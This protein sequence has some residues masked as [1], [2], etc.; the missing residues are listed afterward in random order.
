M[1]RASTLDKHLGLCC[2]GCVIVTSGSVYFFRVSDVALTGMNVLRRSVSTY[3]I[4]Q[5][6]RLSC[7]NEA[8]IGRSLMLDWGFGNLRLGTWRPQI[9]NLMFVEK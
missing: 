1:P 3:D 9:E 4:V 5:Y 7:T 2:F 8:V 6:H